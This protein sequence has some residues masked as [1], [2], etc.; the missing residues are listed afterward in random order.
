MGQFNDKCC[1]L[2]YNS[3]FTNSR[4][5]MHSILMPGRLNITSHHDD[6]TFKV[7][8]FRTRIRA[9]HTDTCSTTNQ[10]QFRVSHYVL[11][12]RATNVSLS[13]VSP[14]EPTTPN[15]DWPEPVRTYARRMWGG[16][17]GIGVHTHVHYAD[18]PER[19]QC[20]DLRGGLM[21]VVQ[22]SRLFKWPECDRHRCPDTAANRH[23]NQRRYS[24][25][26]WSIPGSECQRFR[27]V[28]L[29]E[30][31]PFICGPY[32]AQRHNTPN[33][34]SWALLEDANTNHVG[35]LCIICFIWMH[36]EKK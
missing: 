7:C 5:R 27:F 1:D 19:D 20:V 34:K 21:C 11:C 35:L 26:L 22:T 28:C 12:E 25:V 2:M 24:H 31:Q 18:A 29:C 10:T 6:R 9:H 33:P 17:T 23:D 8:A 30:T 13:V 3:L 15:T 4:T 32:F 36:S 16:T 14:D